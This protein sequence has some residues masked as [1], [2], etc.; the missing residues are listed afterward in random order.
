MI[1]NLLVTGMMVFSASAFSKNDVSF[2]AVKSSNPANIKIDLKIE[3]VTDDLRPESSS[4]AFDISKV[5]FT[6]NGKKLSSTEGSKAAAVKC[7]SCSTNVVHLILDY[8]GSV[9]DQ[10]PKLIMGT[11]QFL[12]KLTYAPGNTIVRLSFIA[13]DDGL[14]NVKGKKNGYTALSDMIMLLNSA[15]CSSF[16]LDGRVDSLSMCNSDTA[17]RLNSNLLSALEQINTADFFLQKQFSNIKYSMIVLTDGTNTDSGIADHIVIDQVAQFKERNG[18][19]FTLTL[20]SKETDQ[21]YLSDL[22]PNKGY[23]F[24]NYSKF[25][26]KLVEL[27]KDYSSTLPVYYSLLICSAVRN[28]DNELKLSSKKYNIPETNILVNAKDFRGGCDTNDLSQWNF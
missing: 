26:E 7:G 3:N 24:K 11:Q 16:T 15:S 27:F 19:F 21:K 28:G 4:V 22:K 23:V 25:S 20:D 10:F 17:T 18:M 8:S 12:Q 1:K 14:F 6:E 5:F 13:G 9:R 2:L